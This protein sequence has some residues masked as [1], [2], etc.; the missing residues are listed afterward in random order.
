VHAAEYRLERAVWRA[1]QMPAVWRGG[2][3]GG[4]L[5]LDID[6][7]RSR[8]TVRGSAEI[9]IYLMEALEMGMLAGLAEQA[10]QEDE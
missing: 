3:M 8:L 5:G 10:Q 7:A 2:A 1:C 6:A 9:E 4:V